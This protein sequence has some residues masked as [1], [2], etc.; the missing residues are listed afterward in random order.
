MRTIDGVADANGH[1]ADDPIDCENSQESG[2][3][4]DADDADAKI[5][6][7]PGPGKKDP[8]GWRGKL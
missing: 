3:A 2:G 4:D 7:P 1:S 5:P 6:S 8:D